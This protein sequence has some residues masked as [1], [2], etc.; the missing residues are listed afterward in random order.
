LIVAAFVFALYLAIRINTCFDL[1]KR[2]RSIVLAVLGMTLV[3]YSIGFFGLGSRYFEQFAKIFDGVILLS[4]VPLLI[5][6]GI[7]F[8]AHK[9]YKWPMA[10]V[11]PLIVAVSICSAVNGASVP[12]VERLTI[13]IKS[14]P[15]NASGF[16]IAHISDLH[17]G[18]IFDEDWVLKTVDEV[19]DLKPDLIAITGDTVEW[20]DELG[21]QWSYHLAKLEAPYGVFMTMGNHDPCSYSRAKK[22]QDFN[23]KTGI[24]M[25]QN[26]TVTLG[27]ALQIAGIDDHCG[28]IIDGRVCGEF[29]RTF[30]DTAPDKP[31]VLL[32]HQPDIFD[33]TI[34]KGVDLQLSGHTHCGQIPLLELFITLHFKYPRGVYEKGDSHIHTSC[35]TG[36]WGTPMRFLSNNEITLITLTP[37]S[38]RSSAR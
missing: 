14:L 36:L 20:G 38:S 17:I 11:L 35:G 22:C 19:N 12:V 28:R 9:T 2:K 3:V 5:E 15:K 29:E 30:E 37:Y 25:L 4:V 10:I 18:E 21:V 16:T 32:S 23:R 13:P 34:K 24:R 26:E 1:D 33:E 8:F 27:N 6:Y 31:L 7:S